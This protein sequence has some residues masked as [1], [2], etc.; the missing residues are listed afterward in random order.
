MSS[1]Y[2][3]DV[4]GLVVGNEFLDGCD[5]LRY[6]RFID[7]QPVANL[8]L[9][10]AQLEVICDDGITVLIADFRAFGHFDLD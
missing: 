2:C 7:L 10:H 3:C 4:L 6:C 1:Q 8:L 5:E 9:L